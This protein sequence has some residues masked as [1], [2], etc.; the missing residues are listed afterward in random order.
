MPFLPA[1][2]FKCGI[3]RNAIDP[4][5]HGRLLAKGW[6]GMPDLYRDLLEE[7]IAIHSIGTVRSYDLEQQPFVLIEPVLKNIPLYAF[8]HD[9]LFA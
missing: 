8:F 5:R 3:D 4:G 1:G 2:P 6:D 7:I 9:S